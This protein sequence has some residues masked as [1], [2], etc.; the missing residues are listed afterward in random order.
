MKVLESH[1]FNQAEFFPR[2]GKFGKPSMIAISP[3]M[4][5]IKPALAERQTSRTRISK[6]TGT[7]YYLGS[8]E[9]E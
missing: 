6:S 1:H 3:Q 4:I 7:P 5:T 8:E 2:Q 9:R